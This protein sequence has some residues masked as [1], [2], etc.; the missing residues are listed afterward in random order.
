MS[1][2]FRVPLLFKAAEDVEAEAPTCSP[3]YSDDASFS[4][5]RRSLNAATREAMRVLG[6]AMDLGDGVVW[7]MVTCV[8][9]E[10]CV[11]SGKCYPERSFFSFGTP[12]F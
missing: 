11:G 1:S 7:L 4:M 8:S 2:G 3:I 12:G 5:L 6:E 9:R 10:E